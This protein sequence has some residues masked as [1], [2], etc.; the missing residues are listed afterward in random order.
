MKHNLLIYTLS[1]FLSFG[2]YAQKKEWTPL[3]D[4]NFTNWDK[5]LGVPHYSVEGI[6]SIPKGDGKEGAKPL[7]L[8]NDP[9]DVFRMIEIGG[10]PVLH[11]SGQI[12]GALTS[13][14]VYKNYHL[15]M[16]FK[17]GDKKWEPRLNDKKDNGLLYH[18]NGNHGAFWNVWMESQEFQVQVGDMGD[19]FGLAGGVNN[20]NSTKREDGFYVYNPEGEENKL[21]TAVEGEKMYRCVRSVDYEKPHGE[22]N[23]LELI[24]FEGKSYHIVNGHVVMILNNAERKTDNGF[25][26]VT[27]GK[28]QIQSEAAEAFYRR[29]QIKSITASDLPENMGN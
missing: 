10:E 5:F 23:T 19:Y 9:L 20:I 6:D 21:G 13:K 29:I 4:K 17:W 25:E 12:Y 7:G 15:K 2:A 24:C 3:L 18:C 28:L 27:S 8:N 22:W 14:E 1:I 26:P 16:E 11:I